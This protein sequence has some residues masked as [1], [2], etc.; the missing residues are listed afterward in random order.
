MNLP[1]FNVV[2]SAYCTCL[3]KYNINPYLGR[4]AHQCIYCYAVKFPSFNG[5]VKP[6]L[7][8]KDKIL[9]MA[10]DTKFKLPI[11]LSD[12]TDPYQPLEKKLG[13]T[14]RCIEVLADR[15]FPILIVTKSDLV[16]RDLDILRRTSTVVS[17]TV[18]TLK[19]D[20]SRLIEPHAPTPSRRLEAL[21]K[22]AEEGIP[23][24]VRIDP[25]IPSLT[26]KMDELEEIVLKSSEIGVKQIT[27]STMKPVRGFFSKLDRNFPNLS[28]KLR[29]AYANKEWIAGYMYL[30]KEERLEMLQNLKAI[31]LKYGIEFATCREGF[32]ELNTTLCDG[33]SYC[34]ESLNR[35]L[36]RDEKF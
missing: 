30:R 3:P 15:K 27:A 14:R 26:S 13:I 12:C 7:D 8:L 34:R 33:T 23:T 16:I 17:M 20:L 4:C 1:L 24:V 21:R 6:R 28:R 32:P 31:V 11:M 25:I 22:V 9:K 5:P 29:E 19:E 18:T 2:K 10:E 36:K 35:Y